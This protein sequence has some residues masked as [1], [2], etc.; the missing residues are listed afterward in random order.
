M[1]GNTVCQ[2]LVTVSGSCAGRQQCHVCNSSPDSLAQVLLS[3]CCTVN[4]LYWV[5]VSYSFH[6]DFHARRQSVLVSV[7]TENSMSE[8]LFIFKIKWQ[9]RCW[10]GS[11]CL[12]KYA[13]GLL[14]RPPCLSGYFWTDVIFKLITDYLRC[15]KGSQ[16]IPSLEN[17]I[18]HSFCTCTCSFSGL[19]TV[20]FWSNL[21]FLFSYSR[22]ISQFLKPER[23]L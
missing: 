10:K 6:L 1:H 8:F 2:A 18:C 21:D 17:Q 5:T 23:T 13:A 12:R 19:L 7:A 22:K 15:Q 16:C 14:Q 20:L 9:N 4:N 11:S 3:H